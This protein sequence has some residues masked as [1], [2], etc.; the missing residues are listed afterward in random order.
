MNKRQEYNQLIANEITKF[1]EKNPD[2]RFIQI[3]Y[4]L[5]IISVTYENINCELSPKVDDRFYEESKITLDKLRKQLEKSKIS[6]TET[7]LA[8]F[9]IQHPNSEENK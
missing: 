8:Q 6:E 4:N 3:L 1:I 2:L 9:C 5:G 7:R